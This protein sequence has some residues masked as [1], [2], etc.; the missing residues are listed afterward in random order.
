MID[1]PSHLADFEDPPL[2]E[3]VLGVQFVAPINYSVINSVEVWQLF[4]EEFP[5]VEERYALDPVF[6]IFGGSGQ[7]QVNFNFRHPPLRSRLWFISENE[8][9]LL[10]FQEDRLFLNWRRKPKNE[11]YPRF[12]S[13]SS[14]FEVYL[15]RLQNFFKQR[16]GVPVEFNQAEITYINLIKVDAYSD[17]PKWLNFLENVGA[18]IENL[19]FS[20][21]EVVKGHEGFPVARLFHDIRSAIVNS[22]GSAAFNLSLTFRGKPNQQDIES[23]MAFLGF[24][25]ETIV[26]R[27]E[28]IT[29]DHAHEFWGRLE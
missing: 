20:F 16:F 1:R 19:N 12:E 14:S 26:Q 24:G 21:S 3:V 22:D 27:F 28:K 18:E 5:T 23:A 6:E 29:T 11:S 25:R 13:I 15:S 8:S 2:D 10:Q 17:L 7:Q 9:H 4:K